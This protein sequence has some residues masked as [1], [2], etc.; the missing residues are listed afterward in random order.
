MNFAYNQKDIADFY[1]IYLSLIEF[2]KEIF[3]DGV[4]TIKYENLIDDSESQIKK[5]LKYCDL[6]WDPNCLNHH[7][8][9]SAIKT[10]SIS[11]ARK[12]IYKSSK[13]LNQNYAEYLREMFDLLKE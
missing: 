1:N 9:K 4:Y 12:P 11:Q 7:Q 10:A 13:N 8:N 3:E 5:I 6:E 2:W